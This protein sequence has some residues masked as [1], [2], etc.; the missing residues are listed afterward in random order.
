MIALFFDSLFFFLFPCCFKHF[1]HIVII[2][3]NF[4]VFGI[5]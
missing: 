1:L 4:S 3:V 5:F 2:K